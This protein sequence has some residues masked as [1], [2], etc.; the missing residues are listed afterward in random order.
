VFDERW[1]L[2]SGSQSGVVDATFLLGR[3]RSRTTTVRWDAVMPECAP[4]DDFGGVCSALRPA[5]A[6]AR[7]RC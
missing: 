3:E 5:R 2:L 6:P 1:V 7:T 4:L